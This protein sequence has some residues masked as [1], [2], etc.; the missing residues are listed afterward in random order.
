MFG[1]TSLS[2]HV[3]RLLYSTAPLPVTCSQLHR[4]KY[5]KGC[6]EGL[7]CSP[8]VSTFPNSPMNTTPESCSGQSPRQQCTK[9]FF[10]SLCQS[11][12]NF[13]RQWG[14]EM[15][16]KYQCKGCIRISNVSCKY[17]LFLDTRVSCSYRNTWEERTGEQRFLLPK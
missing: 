11:R 2:A 12:G 7:P 4:L 6:L 3:A 16:Y 13:V 1:S 9:I 5:H 8:A 10:F 14:Q 17:I 15:Q